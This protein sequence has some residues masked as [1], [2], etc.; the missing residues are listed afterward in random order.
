MHRTSLVLERDL[1]FHCRFICFNHVL[2]FR[3]LVP[4]LLFLVSWQWQI[5]QRKYPQKFHSTEFCTHS[6]SEVAL[7]QFSASATLHCSCQEKG[8][9]RFKCLVPLPEIQLLYRNN[10]MATPYAGGSSSH[11]HR[12][13]QILYFCFGKYMRQ[14]SAGFFATCIHRRR[15]NHHLGSLA[16]CQK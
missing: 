2:Q 10:K 14:I 4:Q 11:I 7:Q 16:E 9:H 13:D 6:S 1:V 8:I 12:K 3:K 15:R 5:V